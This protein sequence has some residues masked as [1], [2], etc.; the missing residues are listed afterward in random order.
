MFRLETTDRPRPAESTATPARLENAFYQLSVDPQKGAI[1]QLVDKETGLDVV[2]PA[3]PW[4]FGQLFRE[5]L[6]EKRDFVA[7]RF[8]RLPW[9]NITLQP[10]VQGPVWKSVVLAGQLDGCAPKNGARLEVRLYE[11]EK[12]IEFHWSIR[13]LP[14]PSAEA[15]YTARHQ[16][17]GKK[18]NDDLHM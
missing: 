18:S 15:I 9:T 7:E 5:T 2:D 10:G 6:T 13:K 3:R 8:R 12:R 1:T 14:V 16:V 4:G 11:S 17:F